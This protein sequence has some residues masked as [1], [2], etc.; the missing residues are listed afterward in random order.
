[1]LFILIRTNIFMPKRYPFIDIRKSVQLGKQLAIT[2]N[3][4]WC[5]KNGI[6]LGDQLL[7]KIE[8]IKNAKDIIVKK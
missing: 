5:K 7:V 3:R 1:M 4:E 6:K 8:P 2:L